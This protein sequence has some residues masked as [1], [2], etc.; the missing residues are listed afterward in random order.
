MSYKPKDK[1]NG[2]YA[3][4]IEEIKN[5]SRADIKPNEVV[6][7]FFPHMLRNAHKQE[8]IKISTVELAAKEVLVE[9]IK[10]EQQ[11]YPMSL[12]VKDII[13]YLTVARPSL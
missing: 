10:A 6:R 3:F 1:I 13:P 11:K 8:V 9:M 2:H 5:S 4:D 12:K 7:Y